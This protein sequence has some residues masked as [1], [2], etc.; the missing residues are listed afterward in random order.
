MLAVSRIFHTTERRF[1]N[2]FFVEKLG[3]PKVRDLRG[4]Q[5]EQFLSWRRT[6]GPDG[7][8]RTTPL[9]AQTIQKDRAIAHRILAKARR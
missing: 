2:E 6:R 8:K 3:D 5:F 7:Q 9:S 4:S 1:A